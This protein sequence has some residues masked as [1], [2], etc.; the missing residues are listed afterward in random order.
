MKTAAEE[1]PKISRS[2]IQGSEATER[3]DLADDERKQSD[4]EGGE[5]G[6]AD[7]AQPFIAGKEIA[8]QPLDGEREAQRDEDAA[9][10]P[11]HAAHPAHA[12]R[13]GR[14]EVVLLG[15]SLELRVPDGYG[16]G[17]EGARRAHGFGNFLCRRDGPGDGALHLSQS[18]MR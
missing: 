17:R 2:A 16:I 14:D 8:D 18:P 6:K 10:D 13:R 1:Y 5:R 12:P 4:E 3:R 7:P 11:E 15:R 9:R